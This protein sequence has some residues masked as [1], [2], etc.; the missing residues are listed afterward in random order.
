MD[1]KYYIGLDAHSEFCVFVVMNGRGEVIQKARVKTCER[2]LI[3]FIRGLKGSKAVTFEETT[4]SQWLYVFLKNEVDK[5]VV[6][7]PVYNKK[8]YSAKTDFLDAT[9]LAD[10][11]RVNR[12]QSVFHSDDELMSLRTLISGY[13]DLVQ[14]LTRTKNRY[15]ATYRKS[16]IKLEKPGLYTNKDNISRLPCMQQQY[17]AKKLLM[18]MELLSEQKK[19]YE[20]R[21]RSNARK[22]KPIRLIMTI[23]G[24][25]PILANQIVGIVVSPYRFSRKGKFFAYAMLV[26]HSQTSDGTVYGKTRTNGRRQLKAVFRIATLSALRTES[27]FRRKYDEM[28]INGACD[29]TARQAVSRAQAAAV[30]GIWKSGKKYNDK[31]RELMKANGC[32]KYKLDS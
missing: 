6:C 32:R 5:L 4:V 18:Q 31:H 12:L 2:D 25:G 14:E 3:D 8:R 26:K 23:P 22:H 28:R 15:K 17:V 20:G 29:R 13:E 1:Y 7:N 10:L 21:F 27:V 24:F 11:L 9:E 19:E 30:L 16:A